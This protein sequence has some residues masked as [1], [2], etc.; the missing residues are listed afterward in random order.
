MMTKHPAAFP[1][2]PYS[3]L[4]WLVVVGARRWQKSWVLPWMLALAHHCPLDSRGC[5]GEDAATGLIPA[6]GWEHTAFVSSPR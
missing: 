3:T 1:L 6:G 5:C 2:S 4:S